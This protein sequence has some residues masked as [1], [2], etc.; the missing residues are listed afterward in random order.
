MRFR[1]RFPIVVAL[2]LTL[3][4]FRPADAQT[5]PPA[6][7]GEEAVCP[8]NSHTTRALLA[9]DSYAQFMWDDGSHNDLF[10]RFGHADKLMVSESLSSDPG[11]GYDGTE[12]AVSG[13][14]ARQWV[15]TANYPWITNTVNAL[16]A[17]PNVDTVVLSIGGNDILAGRT[18]G[19]WYKDMDLDAPGSEEALFTRV[20]SDTWT[21]MSATLAVRPGIEV[22]ISAYD[23]PNLNTGVWCELYA[24]PLRRRLSRDPE[25][26]LIT[27][28]EINEMM[29]EVEQWRIGWANSS[30]R[31]AFDNGMGL[32]HYFY[33]DGVNAPGTLPYPGVSPPDYAPFP[34]GNPQLPSLRMNFR[35][36]YDPLHLDF[37]GYRYKIAH[38]LAGYFLPRWRGTPTATFFSQGG[39]NDGWT[40]GVSSGTGA[41]IVGD[42]GGAAIAGILSFDTGA[43]PDDALV[44]GGSLY[45]SRSGAQGSNPFAAGNL[46]LPVVDVVAGT[47]GQPDVEPADAT[48]PADAADAGCTH[49]TVGA[50]KDALRIDLTSA[51]L[52]ALNKSGLTQFRLAFT[53]VDSGADNVSFATGNAGPDPDPLDLPSLADFVGSRAPFLD[54][55]YCLAAATV[56]GLAGQ[57]A[58]GELLLS[59]DPVA[60][61][62][63]YEVWRHAED[64]YFTA[65]DDCEAAAAC[66]VTGSPPFSDPG[67]LG[68]EGFNHSYRVRARNGCALVAPAS[69]PLGTFT[70]SLTPGAS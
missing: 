41:I 29:V 45:L 55:D 46:G 70:F 69:A 1:Y 32:M 20:Q 40:D 19:G 27:D 50:D 3:A 31:V 16:Q 15:D 53:A 6:A 59:W 10:D 51:G 30:P 42:D 21:I 56:G 36:A 54:V 14:E 44:T 22:L 38:Q 17:H 48:A 49:G 47:F 2:F 63:A 25:N 12:Y 9:G 68:D 62:V 37:D 39:G 67:S 18:D 8:T 60:D 26:D 28:A 57:I 43:I 24:C 13:S 66:T 35:A 33:G 58:A 64:P 5:P 11:P 7:G 34:G 61:A 4:L 52:A 23:Y 65:G